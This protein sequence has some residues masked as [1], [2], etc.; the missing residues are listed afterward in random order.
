MDTTVVQT[1]FT[2]L[3]LATLQYKW[4]EKT[5]LI[6]EFIQDKEAKYLISYAVSAPLYKQRKNFV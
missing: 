4:T 1:W 3:F 2:T 5:Y 6:T